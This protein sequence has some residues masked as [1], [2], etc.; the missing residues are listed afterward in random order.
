METKEI[1][2]VV[3]L[4]EILVD[5]E[6]N[7]EYKWDIEKDSSGKVKLNAEGSPN[8]I[9]VGK[10]TIKDLLIKALNSTYKGEDPTPEVLYDRGV[11]ISKIRA[12]KETVS[13]DANDIDL[14][15]KLLPKAISVPYQY[16][17]VYQAIN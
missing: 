15:K 13:L 11:L 7:E 4:V 1:I 17:Q 2:K 6:G 3:N 14:I 10:L 16:L 5:V 9:K 8:L 12:S